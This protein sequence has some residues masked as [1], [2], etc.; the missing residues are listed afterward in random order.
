MK[1]N[2]GAAADVGLHLFSQPTAFTGLRT[3][4]LLLLRFGL[5]FSFGLSF[6]FF[7]SSGSTSSIVPRHCF[8]PQRQAYSKRSSGVSVLSQVS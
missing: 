1:P 5:G 6:F 4:T 3:L 8:A 2:N 7:T